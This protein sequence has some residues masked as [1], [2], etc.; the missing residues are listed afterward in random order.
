M[1]G[2]V[3]RSSP[4][5]LRLEM[6]GRDAESIEEVVVYCVRVGEGESSNMLHSSKA[7]GSRGLQIFRSVL[8]PGS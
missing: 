5:E 6:V 8:G 2:N 3:S 1:T 4:V 7:I